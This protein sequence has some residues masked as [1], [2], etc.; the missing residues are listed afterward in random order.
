MVSKNKEEAAQRVDD[1]VLP[2]VIEQFAGATNTAI[3]NRLGALS[4]VVP[5]TDPSS[6]TSDAVSL[7]E[8]VT[9]DAVEFLWAHQGAIQRGELT[10]QQVLAGHRFSMPLSALGRSQDS[11]VPRDGLPASTL[12][13]WGSADYTSYGNVLDGVEFDGDIFLIAL[14]LDMQPRADLITGLAVAANSSDFDY[15]DTQPEGTEGTYTVNITTVNPYVS[16]TASEQLN[17]W[18]S[19]GYGRGERQLALKGGTTTSKG[20]DWLS[21]AGGARFQLWEGDIVVDTGGGDAMDAA[22]V[23]SDLPFSLSLKVEG[24][25]AQFM[26]VD[27]QQARLATEAS[28]RFSMEA[29]ALTTAVELGLRLRSE[30]AAGVEL[31]GSLNWLHEQTGLS[32]TAHGRVLLAGGDHKEWGIGGRLRYRP[33]NSGEGLNIVLEPSIGETGSRLADLWSIDGSDLA[34][35]SDEPQTQLRGEMSYGVL[36]GAGVLTPYSSLSLCQGGSSTI[37][38][39]LRYRLP[40]SIELDLRGEREYCPVNGRADHRIGLQLQTAL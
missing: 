3:T 24:A 40:S 2:E 7:L 27:V 9:T 39:G 28:R 32:T 1:V 8:S 37:G 19:V 13:F 18:A 26:G 12:A 4:L 30:E 25:T 36:Y 33:R 23:W 35:S 10:L 11:G 21:L 5:P 17:L 16:W 15:V 29:G 20:S 22:T 34:F 14:G 6:A 38:L 31:G